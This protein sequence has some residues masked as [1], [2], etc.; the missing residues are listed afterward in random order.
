MA[1]PPLV[2]WQHARTS[3]SEL[4]RVSLLTLHFPEMGP[5][6]LVAEA[7]PPDPAYFL[8]S[9]QSSDDEST[10]SSGAG[11]Y[12]ASDSFWAA[13][14]GRALADCRSMVGATVR[15]PPSAAGQTDVSFQQAAAPLQQIIAPSYSS[16]VPAA[17]QTL[18]QDQAHE[19]STVQELKSILASYI[20][21]GHSAQEVLHQLEGTL[22]RYKQVQQ[23]V[24]SQ[25]ASFT[26]SW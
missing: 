16:L 14:S 11:E 17:G 24:D 22:G 2:H 13:A 21:G 6:G 8:T 26:S 18:G 15:M 19:E 23:P 5:V 25:L 1:T 10:A 7:P 3:D 9:E 4:L 20:E 12:V